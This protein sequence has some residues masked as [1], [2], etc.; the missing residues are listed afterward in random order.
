MKKSIFMLAF[1]LSFFSCNTDDEVLQSSE[2]ISFE[3]ESPQNIESVISENVEIITEYNLE[4]LKKESLKNFQKNSFVNMLNPNYFESIAQFE[5]I[6]EQEASNIQYWNTRNNTSEIYFEE[7][8]EFYSF[9]ETIVLSDYFNQDTPIEEREEIL[10]EVL[11]FVL[12]ENIHLIN[13][14][15]QCDSGY[16]PCI[17][18]AENAHSIRVAGCTAGAIV[19]AIV[20]GGIG[21]V[22]W[23]VCMVTSGLLY[24][25]DVDYCGQVF[26]PQQ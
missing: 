21:A 19:A 8:E 3:I 24:A 6:W 7:L 5:Q 10:A 23:P 1:V 16:G 2:E 15:S 20:T 13:N 17:Q 25:N 4:L 18:H 12:N 14:R 26:C 9:G 11:Q 22:S